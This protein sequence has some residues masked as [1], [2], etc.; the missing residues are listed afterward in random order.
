MLVYAITSQ[1]CVR[2]RNGRVYGLTVEGTKI[3]DG[4][5]NTVEEIKRFIDGLLKA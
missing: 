4:I 2:S 5:P 1:E 3:A